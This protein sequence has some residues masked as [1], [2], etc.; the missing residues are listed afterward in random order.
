MM[1]R[2]HGT[3]NSG[4][5]SGPDYHVPALEKGLDI[6]ECLAAQGIPLS[7]AQV[8]RALGRRPTELFRM[9]TALERRG[10]IQRDPLSG[11]YRLTMRLYELGHAHSPYDG[12]LR[13][14]ERPMRALTEEV[15]QSC[16]LSVIHRG[17]LFVL[18]EE[19]SPTR[20]RLSVE[21]GSSFP[22]LNA[23]SGRLLLAYL[24]VLRREETLAQDTDFPRLPADE[25]AALLDHL[26]LIRSRGYE[27]ARSETVE[28]I[29][30]VAV[31]VGTEESR[32]QVALTIAAL[33]R[34]HEAFVAEALPAL[35]RGAET[36]ARSAGL[37]VADV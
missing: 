1:S 19:Q 13:A 12:L 5:S 24:D 23:A 21:V 29:S 32:T 34:D 3:D 7:Q 20:N 4:R 18:A 26:A 36:I 11:A 8:A 17:Q 2:R 37:L 31:L 16:H 14:A 30:D 35:R 28:G 27:T 9:L 33:A 22:L 25:Q 10:Y 6:L 15:R